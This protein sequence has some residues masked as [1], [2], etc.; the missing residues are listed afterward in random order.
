MPDAVF[1][2]GVKLAIETSRGDTPPLRS[3]FANGRWFDIVTEGIPDLI[4]RQ[5]T[6]FPPGHAGRRAMNQQAPVVGRKWSE[7]GLTANVVADYLGALLYGALGTGS[8]NTVPSTTTNLKV[9]E[10]LRADTDVVLTA[11]PS[12]GGAILEF[13]IYNASTGGL[14]TISGIDVYGNGA[15]ETISYASSGSFYTRTS[16]S[17]VA[18]SNINLTNSNAF[19]G[20]FSIHG[21]KY[22]EHTFSANESTN[23][24]FSMERINDP[25]SGAASKSFMHPALV[26]QSLTL[27]TPAG[28]TDGVMTAESTFQGDPAEYQSPAT[29]INQASSLRIWP[30]WTLSV[31]RNNTS[32]CKITNQTL[33]VNAGGRNYFAACGTQS[34]QGSFFGPQ[35]VTGSQDIL[36]DDEVEYLSWLGASRMNLKFIWTT[37]WKLTSTDYMTLSASLSSAFVE[38]EPGLSDDDGAFSLSQD[39]RTITDGTDG[40]VKFT[41]RNGVPKSAYNIA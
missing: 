5:A 26:L 40:I 2:H 23:P 24:T 16:W 11:Q 19:G 28:A 38:G 41:L 37:P 27:N 35:E 3:W 29:T 21:F 4:P 6:I 33:T 14:I 36:I 32:Y 12:N 25:Q 9:N 34:P 20:S 7:G 8:T 31:T 10:A 1:K 22:W 18:A 39:F 13:A 17:S 15:S 30:A